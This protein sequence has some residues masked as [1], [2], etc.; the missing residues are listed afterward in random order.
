MAH[1]QALIGRAVMTSLSN[2][3]DI[4]KAREI[5]RELRKARDKLQ[6]AIWDENEELKNALHREIKRLESMKAVGELYDVDY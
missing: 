5:E 1:L 6:D 3:P 4:L 2:Y